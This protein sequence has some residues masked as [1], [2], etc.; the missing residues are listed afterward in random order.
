MAETY[1][2]YLSTGF[3]RAAPTRQ[4]WQA[5]CSRAPV[6]LF[7]ADNE[8]DERRAHQACNEPNALDAQFSTCCAG[9]NCQSR[10]QQAQSARF[11]DSRSAAAT[12]SDDITI[13]GHGTI[14]RQGA[15][16][17][18]GCAGIQGDAGE[19]ENISLKRRRCAESRGAANLPV[20][21][22]VRQTIAKNNG[23][24]ARGRQRTTYLKNEQRVGITQGVE[25]QFPCQLSGVGKKYA[26]GVR[27]SPPKSVPVSVAVGDRP[28][29]ALY[30]VVR[31]A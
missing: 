9:Q 20:H 8:S 24:V 26:P 5:C 21:V 30:A 15:P 7:V 17:T 11:W 29:A 14:S 10:P 18:D 28:M 25:G 27:T 23:R 13:Q 3:Q 22:R 1:T 2:S 31:S 19:R 6:V 4:S 12:A 16:A